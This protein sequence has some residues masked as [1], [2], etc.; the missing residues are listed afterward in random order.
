VN[1]EG[2]ALADPGETRMRWRF[3]CRPQTQKERLTRQPQAIPRWEARPS[4]YPTKS[5]RR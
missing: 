4:K 2:K 1:L 5:K 3:L